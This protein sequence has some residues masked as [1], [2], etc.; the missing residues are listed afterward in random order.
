MRA[1]SPA[2]VLALRT[3]AQRRQFVEERLYLARGLQGTDQSSGPLPDMCPHVRHL[4]RREE[5]IAW[6]QLVALLAHLD[7]VFALD[8]VPPL[9]LLVVHVAHRSALL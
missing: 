7:Y 8:N 9:V 1:E 4:S 5:R 3:A 6:P 2:K